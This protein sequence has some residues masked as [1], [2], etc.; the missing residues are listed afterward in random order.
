MGPIWSRWE[1]QHWRLHYI[2]VGRYLQSSHHKVEMG[3][4]LA[5]WSKLFVEHTSMTRFV[6]KLTIPSWMVNYRRGLAPAV[7]GA[8]TYPEL[9][10]TAKTEERQQLQLV[11]WKHYVPR[12]MQYSDNYPINKS[13]QSVRMW[14]WFSRWQTHNPPCLNLVLRRLKVDLQML[15]VMMNR[16]DILI[17]QLLYVLWLGRFRQYQSMVLLIQQQIISGQLFCKVASVAHLRRSIL[18]LLIT[19]HVTKLDLMVIW[20]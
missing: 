4:L 14:V 7:S 13:A 11:K 12:C 18:S 9:C 3:I 19:H 1:L 8:Q 5:A 2:Q 10:L 20:S 15:Q 17:L 6:K 16:Y